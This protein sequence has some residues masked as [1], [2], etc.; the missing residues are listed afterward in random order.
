M[1]I[2]IFEKMKTTLE[3]SAICDKMERG[4]TGHDVSRAD[5]QRRTN[6]GYGSESEY[7]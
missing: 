2:D 5:S 1:S 7:T 3:I 6:D 4:L